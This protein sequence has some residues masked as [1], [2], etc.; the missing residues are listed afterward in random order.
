[1]SEHFCKNCINSNGDPNSPVCKH[2]G[3]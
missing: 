2:T 3:A 1:M